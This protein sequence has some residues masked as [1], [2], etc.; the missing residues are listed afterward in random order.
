MLQLSA[1][2]ASEPVP[3]YFLEGGR[4]YWWWDDELWVWEEVRVFATPLFFSLVF[5]S[6]WMQV[7]QEHASWQE[8]IGAAWWPYDELCEWRCGQD[9]WEDRGRGW[10]ERVGWGG[11]GGG[12]WWMFDQGDV[13]FGA[14]DILETKLFTRRWTMDPPPDPSDWLATCACHVLFFIYIVCWL[15]VWTMFRWSLGKIM[16]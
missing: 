2:F 11:R 8:W 15:V 1:M 4:W 7:W 9:F 12:M 14:Q 13:V 5:V 3:K 6:L 10:E 16:E